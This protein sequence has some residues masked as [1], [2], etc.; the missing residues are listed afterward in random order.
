[1]K[2][3]FCGA[4]KLGFS[5]ALAIDS[6]NHD[7]MIYDIN[8][9][10]ADILKTR[11]LPFLEEGAQE[12]LD[13]TRM[14][15]GTL[16]EIVEHGEIIFVP[17]QTPHNP[18]Y[19]GITP[20]PEER[21]DFD[22]SFLKA[23]VKALAEEIERQGKDKI[24]IVISTVLPGTIEREIKPLLNERVKLCYNPFF[25][26]MGQT[27]Q[28]YLH[29]EFV[30]FG[31]DDKQAVATAKAFYR[32]IHDK[33][34]YET[35]IKAA[36]L[37]KVAYNTYIGQKIVFANNLMEI[38]HKL[39]INVDEVTNALKLATD[40]LISPKYLV[41]GM[42][43]GGGCHP[44][45]G[46]AMSW[47]AREL[48]LS[49][50]WSEAVMVAREKQTEWL[51]DIIIEESKKHP[52]LPIVILG[53]AYKPN[54]NLCVGIPALLLKNILEERGVKAEIID[55]YVDRER[56]EYTLLGVGYPEP[57]IYFIGTRHEIFK[58]AHF[59]VGSV[60][61]DVWRYIPE[62]DGVKLLRIGGA[63]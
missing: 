27:I 30:L 56:D 62:K 53:Y 51:A 45:D 40:R 60:V 11:N 55:P 1:M 25:I 21:V 35:S 39:G 26:A 16:S 48:G 52:E 17:I 7:V 42:G 23:G 54:T 12:L 8:P 63:S 50:D 38:C 3:S 28:D 22:Y 10:V 31:V 59:A 43:D 4:G 61:I 29:P 14:C 15:F 36:E 18:R 19:E 41:G 47:L 49:Y 37:I 33:P 24:V 20:I 9:R 57:A 34:F 6:K 58:D 44:R 13:N 46:I 32:T 2:I 5:C